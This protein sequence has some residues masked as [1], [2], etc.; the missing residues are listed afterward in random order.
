MF[1]RFTS[2]IICP[3]AGNHFAGFHNYRPASLQ[4]LRSVITVTVHQQYM[5]KLI[6][7]GE[8]L[9]VEKKQVLEW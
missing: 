9:M 8:L 1:I 7:N 4:A 5:V 6:V 2:I 3:N